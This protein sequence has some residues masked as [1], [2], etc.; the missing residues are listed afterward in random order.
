[1][2]ALRGAVFAFLERLSPSQ[3]SA[4]TPA[5]TSGLGCGRYPR[6]LCYGLALVEETVL[7]L[8]GGLKWQAHAR[9]PPATWWAMTSA[10]AAGRTLAARCLGP[11][12][13]CSAAVLL[14]AEGGDEAE[15]GGGR[16]RHRIL[17]WA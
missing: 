14:V 9:C 6:P 7:L 8:L 17:C 3:S 1:M 5:P 2:A 11:G 4:T 13:A 10:C 12:A 15:G 16:E